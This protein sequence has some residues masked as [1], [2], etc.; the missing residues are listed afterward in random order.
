METPIEQPAAPVEQIVQAAPV[1]QQQA[2]TSPIPAEAAKPVAAPE[3]KY[4]K[5]E[6]DPN[7]KA[8]TE[9]LEKGTVNDFFAEQTKFDRMDA[10]SV[11][12]KDIREQ[13]PGISDKAVDA[14][15]KKKM[16]GY[17]LEGYD[18]ED[19]SL[20]KELME[21][22]AQRIRN[23]W[24]QQNAP[25]PQQA[26]EQKAEAATPSQPSIEDFVRQQQES[27]VKEL[28]ATIDKIT[29]DPEFKRFETERTVRVGGKDGINYEVPKGTDPVKMLQDPDV[30]W[31][32]LKNKDG[33][34]NAERLLRAQAYLADMDAYDARLLAHG[35]KQGS[36]AE[37]TA[38]ENPKVGSSL[39]SAGKPVGGGKKISWG[40]A[41]PA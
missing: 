24:K 29:A 22:D 7:F 9:A 21:S 11:I 31:A 18:D 10:Q 2:A 14:L 33:S 26:T 34:I 13:H 17:S 5:F 4:A 12:K 41:I 27:A 32:G 20:A 39:A 37:I 15:Y 1:E 36:K 16:E 25:K 38:L 8:F 30:L 23:G 3:N 35:V 19:A 28:T 6:S 40:G